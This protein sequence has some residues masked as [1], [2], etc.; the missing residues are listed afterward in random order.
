M[1]SRVI[2]D[3]AASATLL[4]ACHGPTARSLIGGNRN[5]RAWV[6]AEGLGLVVGLEHGQRMSQVPCMHLL[7]WRVFIAHRPSV[8]WARRRRN[9]E[10]FVH[11][12]SLEETLGTVEFVFAHDGSRFTEVDPWSHIAVE[13]A[14]ALEE[15]AHGDGV[16]VAVEGADDAT[17][18]GKW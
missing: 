17:E 10:E 18:G 13:E 2:N 8:R 11:L 6:N 1:I 5:R 16:F 3:S 12:R 14:V 9:E 7:V 15:F 4:R